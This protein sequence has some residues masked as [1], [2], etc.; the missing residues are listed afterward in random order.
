MYEL[1]E[2]ELDEVMAL[3]QDHPYLNSERLLKAIPFLVAEVRKH[4]GTTG[5]T[6]EKDNRID[7]KRVKKAMV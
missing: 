1:T 5:P 6:E 3:H 7:Y 2:R 4:R